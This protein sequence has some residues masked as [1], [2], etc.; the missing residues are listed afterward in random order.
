MTPTT[1][2]L[3]LGLAV[4]ALA[5]F[6]FIPYK[7]MPKVE[8]YKDEEVSIGVG[9]TAGLVVVVFA[10]FFLFFYSSPKEP[11]VIRRIQYYNL[12]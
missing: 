7:K 4:V 12:D 1:K 5:T 11:N 10:V 9:V 2:G 3:I 6:V 8:G